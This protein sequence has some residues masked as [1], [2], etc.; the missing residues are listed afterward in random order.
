V[1]ETAILE[2]EAADGGRRILLVK[3]CRRITRPS[4]SI[5]FFAPERL[6][7]LAHRD[8][9]RC[10]LIV[11]R[12][13][14]ASEPYQAQIVGV[15]PQVRVLATASTRPRCA[16][17]RTALREV[18]ARG[19]NIDSLTDTFFLAL[20]VSLRRRT[21]TADTV[22]SLLASETRAHGLLHNRRRLQ[23]LS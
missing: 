21:T 5:A 3:P 14:A 17:L 13:L 18:I 4:G 9:E 22:T 16:R 10:A 8:P 23:S 12:T 6:V 15:S 11:F 2:N 1:R 7:V 19:H 20:A